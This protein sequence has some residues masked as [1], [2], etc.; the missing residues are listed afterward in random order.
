MN[1]CHIIA[2]FYPGY[3]APFEYTRALAAEGISTDVICI[4]KEE[5]P[6][7]QTID[8]VSVFRPVTSTTD[9]LTSTSFSRFI[10]KVSRHLRTA[11]YDI[12][13]VY[14][15]RGCGTLPLLN[16]GSAEAW[17][18]DI[19]TGSTSSKAPVANFLYR[20][21]CRPYDR[22]VA[23]DEKVGK[24]VIGENWAFSVVP[25]G[26]NFDHFVPGTNVD[27]RHKYNIDDAD[28]VLAFTGRFNNPLRT[29]EKIIEAFA[30]AVER[31]PSLKLM[32]LGDG[33][34]VPQLRGLAEELSVDE[35]IVWTG[36]VAYQQ[37]V[38]YL[39]AADMALAYVPCSPQFD[40]QP[41]LKTA[42]YL[43]C[44]LPTVATATQGNQRFITHGENGLLA[45]DTPTGLGEMIVLLARDAALRQTFAA[46]ARQSVQHYHWQTIV[47][48]Q[49]LPVYEQLLSDR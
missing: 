7:R 23:L 42:E 41:P 44:G 4:G 1:V 22:V 40:L 19:R 45:D 29:P 38:Q 5:E 34:L 37:V 9:F 30:F 11:H 26:A 46:V 2:G 10:W 21:E 25:L 43:A 17:V 15:F 31:E 32:L 47:H 14:A 16:A 6:V 35:R 27:L 20:Q 18:I 3:A 8:G 33:Q 12:V 48:D 13:H 39:H 49:L 28:V 24:L 36:E